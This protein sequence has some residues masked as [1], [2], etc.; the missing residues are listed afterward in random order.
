[1]IKYWIVVANASKASIYSVSQEKQEREWT[2]VT[3][4]SHPQS[5]MKVADL[6]ADAPGHYKSPGEER[7]TFGHLDVKEEEADHFAREI[8][9]FLHDKLN[10]SAFN[11]LILAAAPHF[12]GL[13]NKHL[14]DHI[15]NTMK[16]TIQKDY[17]QLTQKEL[18]EAIFAEG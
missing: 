18:E 1:M 12:Y 5:H 9:K 15:K 10:E 14:D 17:T 2:L 8:T 3:E 13:L 16:K 6:L 7:G 11:H 4:L